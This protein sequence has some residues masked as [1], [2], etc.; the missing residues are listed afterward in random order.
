MAWDWSDQLDKLEDEIRNFG[1]RAKRKGDLPAS[2]VKKLRWFK[3]PTAVYPSFL[4]FLGLVMAAIGFV[5][6]LSSGA[7]VGGA[8]GVLILY[9]LFGGWDM[10]ASEAVA[11]ASMFGGL[12]SR[13]WMLGAGAL[14][15]GIAGRLYEAPDGGRILRSAVVGIGVLLIVLG[16]LLPIKVA[17]KSRPLLVWLVQVLDETG[18]KPDAFWAFY[19]S[20]VV[21]PIS[22]LAVA[23]LGA[24]T[25]VTSFKGAATPTIR[26]KMMVSGGAFVLV[27]FKLV[28][29]A[30]FSM[31]IE[32]VFI[33]GLIYA[34]IYG[35]MIVWAMALAALI[36]R[37]V[38]GLVPLDA[39]VFRDS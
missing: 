29:V 6:Q 31:L 35:A 25:A 19:I 33:G 28:A 17:G 24:F 7:R 16:V 10:D 8:F 4:L 38:D 26:A 39:M 34:W 5:P 32:G 2:T 36:L 12:F 11:Q 23:A 30:A 21:F 3:V 1:D 37:F 14:L 9:S 22:A 18:G 20:F 13:L 27:W 15:I